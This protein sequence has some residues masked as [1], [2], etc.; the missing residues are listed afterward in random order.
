MTVLRLITE[1]SSPLIFP[2]SPNL[3]ILLSASPSQ[4]ITYT[5]FLPESSTP[6]ATVALYT[7]QWFH[8]KTAT[9][10]HLFLTKVNRYEYKKQKEF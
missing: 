3:F 1:I 5:I 8:N 7:F 2:F 10:Y 9:F 6:Q 4:V